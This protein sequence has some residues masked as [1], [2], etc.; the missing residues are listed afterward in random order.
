MVFTEYLLCSGF[1]VWLFLYPEQIL[2]GNVS[3]IISFRR[4]NWELR[5]KKI[6]PSPKILKPIF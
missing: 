1:F 3:D 4:R 2:T 6:V 5:V